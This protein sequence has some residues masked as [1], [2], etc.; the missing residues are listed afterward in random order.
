MPAIPQ[1]RSVS[2][3]LK[4]LILVLK[5]LPWM[6]GY[7]VLIPAVGSFLGFGVGSWQPLKP[8]QLSSV[9]IRPV[10]ESAWV[11]E[12]ITNDPAAKKIVEGYLS[13]LA[14]AGYL[15]AQQGVWVS[16]GKYPIAQHQGE[17]LRPAASLSK[18][19]TTL[20]ALATWGPDSRFETL[21]GWRG[22]LEN[23]VVL[24][25]LV[26][27]GGDDPLFVWE[28]AIALG[29]T[30]QRLGI[31]RVTGDLIIAG[32][33]T[34]NFETNR[35]QSGELLKQALN[36]SQ[37]DY[38]IESA[39]TQLAPGTP[40]PSIQ[41]DGSVRTTTGSWKD[42]VDGWLVR[43]DSLPLVAVLKAMN[44]Y[45]NNPM[46]EQVAN[47]LGGPNAVVSKAE[48]FAGIVPGELQLINGS[49]LGE[50]NQMSPQAAVIMFQKIQ[51]ELRSHGYTVSDIFPIAGRDGG[52]LVDRNM[53]DNA[54]VKTGSL[55]VVS[56]LAGAVP[57][58]KKG[59]VW[60]SL[61]N[62]GSGLDNLRSRQDRIIAQLEQQWGKATEL[63]PEL[64][65]SVRIGEAP[66]KFGDERRNQPIL[67]QIN[68]D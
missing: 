47:T 60:F 9:D 2:K 43:H 24:G 54:V 6:A 38:S 30:L 33:F 5:F 28:E 53:P 49:G 55:A 32:N 4:E 67:N 63:P 50:R 64:Q 62:Y 14:S 15:T 66:Y 56:A 29:N 26:I 27:E 1:C 19:A 22:R 11:Q 35:G 48:D 41:I 40:R 37:W 13:G 58:Q 23:G 31:R 52:T 39:H 36:S 57:T 8:L 42:R 59:L 25:D 7:S 3:G 65:T 61:I 51:D 12:A 17:T 45:S 68:T 16:A 44:I 34:M 10:W 21:V 18:I 20:A 46:A